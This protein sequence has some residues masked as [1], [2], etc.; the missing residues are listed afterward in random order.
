VG[1][2]PAL[3][4]NETWTGANRSTPKESWG[5]RPNQRFLVEVGG[6]GF[7]LHDGKTGAV[8]G[9][10]EAGYRW[11]PWL[12]V[13]AWFTGSAAREQ[14]LANSSATYRRYGLG[15]GLAVGKTVA[16]LFADVSL[17]PELTRTTAAGAKLASGNGGSQWGVAASAWIRAGLLIGPWCPFVFVAGGYALTEEQFK[18]DGSHGY[19]LLTIPP[20][21]ASFGLGL[22]YRFGAAGLEENDRTGPG[23]PRPK[24]P[25]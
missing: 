10:V 21:N 19:D 11:S 22:A 5:Q 4:P 24:P 15:V 17:L 3:G 13:A 7:G 6:F 2:A 14:A 1:A 20:G 23:R 9:G 18:F 12:A 16:P 8:G 25:G